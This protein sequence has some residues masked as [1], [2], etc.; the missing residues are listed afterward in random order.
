MI[1]KLKNICIAAKIYQV[2]ELV[3]FLTAI[4]LIY[5]F[6]I[7]FISLSWHFVYW[8]DIQLILMK[9]DTNFKFGNYILTILFLPCGCQHTTYVVS[10]EMIGVVC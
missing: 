6:F 4:S 10:T 7:Y 5:F 9:Y 8:Y 3:F 2:K 1:K